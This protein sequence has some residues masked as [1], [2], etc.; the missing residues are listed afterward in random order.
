MAS[1]EGNCSEEFENSYQ[2]K[3]S[4]LNGTSYQNNQRFFGPNLQNSSHLYLKQ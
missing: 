1:Q 4:K 3:K 2:Q